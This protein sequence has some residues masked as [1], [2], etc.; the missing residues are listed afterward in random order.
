MLSLKSVYL[1]HFIGHYRQNSISMPVVLAKI[2]PWDMTLLHVIPHC[3]QEPNP[4]LPYRSRA[5]ICQLKA[6]MS[7][8]SWASSAQPDTQALS[9]QAVPL[10]LIGRSRCLNSIHLGTLR[11][12][13]CSRRPRSGAMA[14]QRAQVQ[15]PA[16][17]DTLPESSRKATFLVK[18]G[19]N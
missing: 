18:V 9:K 4:I 1:P 15:L 8:A 7:R 2:K 13:F 3:E 16:T 19:R 10:D 6:A 12:P 14:L 17:T 11:G 5:V